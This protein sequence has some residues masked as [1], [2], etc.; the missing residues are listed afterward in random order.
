MWVVFLQPDTSL[1]HPG[2]GNHNWENS[3]IMLAC[4]QVW[5]VFLINDWCGRVDPWPGG[6]GWYKKAAGGSP[7]KAGQSAAS[8]MVCVSVPGFRFLP[9]VLALA[10]TEDGL[11]PVNQINPSWQAAFG[12]GVYHGHR[13][14]TRTP[15]KL[16]SVFPDHPELLLI[17]GNKILRTRMSNMPK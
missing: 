10:S 11:W 15:G 1:H 9:G 6:P 13:K 7:Q 2:I 17:P 14:W 5:D 16:H 8:L 4:M 12:L 3:S